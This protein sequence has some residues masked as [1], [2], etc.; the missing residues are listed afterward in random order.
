MADT[1]TSID[2][3]IEITLKVKVKFSQ[4]H[5]YGERTPDQLKHE[6]ES[7]KK[8]MPEHLVQMMEGEYQVAE[9]MGDCKWGYMHYTFSVEQSK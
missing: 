8:V 6:I 5:Y 1:H 4:A 7:A 9:H 3:E 2:E